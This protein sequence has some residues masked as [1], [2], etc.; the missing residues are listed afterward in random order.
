MLRP[1]VPGDDAERL[2]V[3]LQLERSTEVNLQ[4]LGDQRH[5]TF[6]HAGLSGFAQREQAEFGERLLPAQRRVQAR[7][8]TA[9]LRDVAPHNDNAGDAAFSVPDGAAIGLNHAYRAV[10]R[11][12]PVLGA[13]SGTGTHGVAENLADTLAILGK[14]IV[15]RIAAHQLR[16]V[17]QQRAVGRAGVD[18]PP[19]GIENGDQ[20]A[21]VAD[22]LQ[23][24]RGR[25]VNAGQIA[26]PARC[27]LSAIA[28]R[29]RTRRF[30]VRGHAVR[31]CRRGSVVQGIHDVAHP[32]SLRR[33][34]DAQ[35]GKRWISPA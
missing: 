17:A 14:D 28:D 21:R 6:D 12:Q 4:H 24:Q 22:D 34:R 9:L 23:D 7:C 10:A 29:G 8:C 35:N 27:G 33:S 16:R 26:F 13:M 20:V 3:R 11:H 2:A 15:Q 5:G 19:F 30:L 31:P 18:V 32:G 1:V 25:P